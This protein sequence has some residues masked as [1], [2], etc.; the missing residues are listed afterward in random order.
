[1]F[2]AHNNAASSGEG[3]V[4]ARRKRSSLDLG[5]TTGAAS[6]V[7]RRDGHWAAT[8]ADAT[9]DA[10]PW[11]SRTIRETTL[12]PGPLK[13]TGMDWAHKRWRAKT[14]TGSD[15][16]MVWTQAKGQAPLHHSEEMVQDADRT[17]FASSSLLSPAL[18][19]RAVTGST[20]VGCV[21]VI[22]AT[23]A[24]FSLTRVTED[25]L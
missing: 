21:A 11:M 19:A 22:T 25:T 15:R 14:P 10:P 23:G 16:V 5:S 18:R 1:M 13:G 20:T 3:S 17:P 6:M 8:T 12:R 9:D 24:R 7:K 4:Q 2:H